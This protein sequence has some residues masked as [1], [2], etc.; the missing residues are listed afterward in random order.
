[1][2]DEE[3]GCLVGED[4][5]AVVRF[6]LAL[7][8]AE[9]LPAISRTAATMRKIEAGDWR[10]ARSYLKRTGAYQSDESQD[11]PPPP[12]TRIAD[13]PD[14]A[15]GRPT[16][17]TDHVH[18]ELVRAVN[19]G[20]FASD[21]AALVGISASTF[22][23]WMQ[24]GEGLFDVAWKLVVDMYTDDDDDDGDDW[25]SDIIPSAQEMADVLD[26]EEWR[27]VSLYRDVSRT[28]AIVR[29]TVWDIWNEVAHYD[30]LA[31]LAALEFRFPHW[32][33]EGIRAEEEFE[34]AEQAR[35]DAERERKR[36][37]ASRA[38]TQPQGPALLTSEALIQAI[39]ELI[40]ERS[41]KNPADA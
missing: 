30:A 9:V 12:V 14:S 16:K 34:R 26:P 18:Q 10:A 5:V 6:Y 38:Q 23:R 37:E 33:D 22:H 29:M 4:K 2:G 32:T 20:A 27:Y 28:Q 13:R 36:A 40:A 39:L 15:G 21:A 7:L 25:V 41:A 11:R 24:R 31:A 17:L 19:T 1:M 3:L 8:R 35:W